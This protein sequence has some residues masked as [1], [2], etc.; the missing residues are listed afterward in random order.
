[1]PRRTGRPRVTKPIRNET[2]RGIVRLAGE[3]HHLCE[4]AYVTIALDGIVLVTQATVGP[5]SF[6][7]DTSA[8]SDG[9]HQLSFV[10]SKLTGEPLSQRTVP[11]RIE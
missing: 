3:V 9:L 10:A 8:S 6:E 4:V 1:M 5:F 7:W 11:I 2:L